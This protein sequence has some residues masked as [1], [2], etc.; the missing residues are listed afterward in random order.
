M[1]QNVFFTYGSQE[2]QLGKFQNTKNI[3]EEKNL[4]FKMQ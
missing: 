2:P 1:T 4:V 3:Y